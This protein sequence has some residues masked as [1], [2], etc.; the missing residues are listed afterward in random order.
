MDIASYIQ[1]GVIESYV[2]G[3]ATPDEV[4]EL[5]ALKLTSPAIEQ[6]IESFSLLLEETALKSAIEPP[7]HIKAKVME[8]IFNTSAS[9]VLPLHTISDSVTPV[10]SI[11]SYKMLAAAAVILFILSA[12]TNFYLYNKYSEKDKAYQALASERNSLYANNQ[13]YQT[14]LRHWDSAAAMMANP[15]MAVIKMK[16]LPGKENNLATLYWDTRNKD[17]YILPNILPHPEAGKQYQLWALVDGKAVDAGVL[18]MDCVGICKM[19][20]IPKAQGFAITL[21]KTGGSPVPTVTSML[22]KGDV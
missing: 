19:K 12:A 5:E 20:N 11:S 22:V 17:V 8:A 10:R 6:A 3:L 18:E 13:I 14:N 1:S 9:P 15:A 16:G 4:A 2:L 21:E 7:S